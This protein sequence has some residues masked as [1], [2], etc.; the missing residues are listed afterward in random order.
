MN[1]EKQTN[2]SFEEFELDTSR[3][4]LLRNGKTVS[5]YAKTY[6]LLTFLIENEGRVLA[7]DEILDSV[8]AGQIV[9]ESNLAVQISALR[10]ALADDKET[11]RFLVTIPGKGYKFVADFDNE[12]EIIIEKQTLTRTT[13]EEELEFSGEKNSE[14]KIPNGMQKIF[15][16][17]LNYKTF[18]FTTVLISLLLFTGFAGYWIYKK[19]SN[20]AIV[21]TF[22]E[23]LSIVQIT[24]GKIASCP[25][26]SPDGKFIAYAENYRT[27]TGTLY[28]HQTDTN[29]TIQLLKPDNRT[30][31]CINFSPDGSHIYYVE[32]TKQNPQG[33]LFT[34]P[35]I[36]GTPKRIVSGLNPCF[37]V[38]PDNK[39]VIFPRFDK[40]KNS[41][42][43]FIA[44]IQSG[45]EQPFEI[46]NSEKYK[47]GIWAAWSPDG[48]T[49]AFASNKQNDEK[50][51]L[52]TIIGV[53][54]QTKA[55]K[56]LTE[57][58]FSGLGKITWT[59]D[60]LNLVFVGSKPR[61]A[62]EIYMM[63]SASGVV[64]RITNDLQEYGNYG[65]GI[66]SDSERIVVNAFN[67]KSEIWSVN[68]EGKSDKAVRLTNG[69]NDGYYGV[70][71]LKDGRIAYI[72]KTS[73]G[74]EIE[75]I[76]EDGN[77]NRF[78]T[79][80]KYFHKDIAASPDG[81]YLVFVSNQTGKNQIFRMN[82]A[83]GSEI[84]Q[85]TFDDFS[86]GKPDISPD[87]Q[88]VIYNSNDGQKSTLWK[89]PLVGGENVRLTDYEANSPVYSPDGKKIACILPSRH[90][91]KPGNLAIIPIDGGEPLKTFPVKKFSWSSETIRWKPDGTA[92]IFHN[93]KTNL[94]EQPIA[95][96][97]PKQLTDF[98]SGYIRNFNYS[99]DG[100]KIFIS[101]GETFVDVVLIK[102][103]R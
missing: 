89:V 37:A 102:N 21:P 31:G 24:D 3:R 79:N 76:N 39:K 7:K 55:I 67:V 103:F 44:D 91:E 5:L 86:K 54:Y 49:I 13:Y 28:L 78:L 16:T 92:I 14:I 9:E 22:D 34:I 10:K 23:Q 43:W 63:D 58:K 66:S 25:T 65:L 38:S 12:T 11:P 82:A 2:I 84:T 77:E 101:R 32:I 19:R 99:N 70:T 56:P 68:A 74:F 59:S 50:N 71:H 61:E 72:A 51:D 57:E 90:I 1:E 45:T 15:Q 60:G 52:F 8:W 83:D 41:N 95:G 36:G 17:F 20:S 40:I 97:E 69:K 81:R 4:K 42:K 75:S 30:F 53:D 29:T 48:K 18:V 62:N 26:I 73:K 6:D 33:I 94:W 93:E 27:G 35:V 87:G 88:W 98:S 46:T 80:D 64:R 85:L 96:G 100:N 47:F